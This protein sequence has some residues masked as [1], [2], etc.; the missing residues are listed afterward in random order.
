LFQL[1]AVRNKHLASE[2]GGIAEMSAYLHCGLP[3]LGGSVVTSGGLADEA[4]FRH[5]VARS[6]GGPAPGQACTGSSLRHSASAFTRDVGS[7]S[8]SLQEHVQNV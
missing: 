5:G 3:A 1:N 4:S 2:A 8:V 6:S 7:S